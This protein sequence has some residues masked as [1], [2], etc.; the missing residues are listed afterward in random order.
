MWRA[1]ASRVDSTSGISIIDASP[2]ATLT[3][4]QPVESHDRLRSYRRAREF[5]R[6]T[7]HRTNQPS[8]ENRR[9]I[10][11]ISRLFHCLFQAVARFNWSVDSGASD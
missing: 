5:G 11:K 7:G 6:S 1:D 8:N 3:I 4:T 10:T 9:L 2:S